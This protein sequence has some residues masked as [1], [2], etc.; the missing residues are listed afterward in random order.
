MSAP[1]YTYS[2]PT[3]EGISKEKFDYISEVLREHNI[4]VVLLEETHNANEA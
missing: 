1:S 3:F 4:D 2:N